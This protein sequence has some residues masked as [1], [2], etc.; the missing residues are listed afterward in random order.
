VK[1]GLWIVL[2]GVAVALLA[3]ALYYRSATAPTH[4]MLEH[5]GGELE[6]LKTEFH[7]NDVQFQ[8][9]RQLHEEYAPKCEQM[10]ARIADAN[11][12]ADRLISAQTAVSP[13]LAAALEECAAVHADCHRA[14]LGHI[15]AVAG[16]MPKDQAARY[17]EMMKVRVL[18]PG[19]MPVGSAGAAR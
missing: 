9:V 15:Y 4:T 19:L 12:K 5:A 6:W 11:A 13:E 2:L 14:M 16:Q 1:R 17:I 7:L 10:C 3:S 8:A 18:D